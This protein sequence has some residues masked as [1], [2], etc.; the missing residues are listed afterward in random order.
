MKKLMFIVII[1]LIASSAYAESKPFQASLVPD[2]AI[3][4]RDTHIK[5]FSL[6]IW[7]ENPNTGFA[8]GFVNGSTGDS[9]GF[10]WGLVNYAQNYT[11]V[12]WAWVNYASGHFTGWQHGIFNY[13]GTLTG[14]QLGWVNFAKSAQSGI[15]IGLVNII[16][17]NQWFTGFPQELAKGMVFVNWRF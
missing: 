4:S 7:G 8:L 16:Q 17:E 3:H 9:V 5:G 2:I 6:N 14:L 15:Q 13:A 12:E 1:C 10:S 11:G